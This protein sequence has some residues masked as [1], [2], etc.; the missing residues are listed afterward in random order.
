MQLLNYCVEH[1][2]FYG[3]IHDEWHPCYDILRTFHVLLNPI[4]IN[5]SIKNSQS[6]NTYI[7]EYTLN[8]IWCRFS[9]I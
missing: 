4:F 6:A 5:K 8:R 1:K 3:H 7:P 2:E 9:W